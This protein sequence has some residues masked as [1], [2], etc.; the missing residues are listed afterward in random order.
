MEQNNSLKV[1]DKITAE[2][3]LPRLAK[4][5]GEWLLTKENKSTFTV[6]GLTPGLKFN[7]YLNKKTGSICR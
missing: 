7:L 5:A 4:G 6:R 2:V 3:N 1:G